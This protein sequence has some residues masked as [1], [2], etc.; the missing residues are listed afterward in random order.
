VP[1]GAIW[2]KIEPLPCSFQVISDDV[3]DSPGERGIRAP[4]L[5]IAG[6]AAQIIGVF[7]IILHDVGDSVH[8]ANRQVLVQNL[9]PELPACRKLQLAPEVL[10]RIIRSGRGPQ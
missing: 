10:E 9:Y 7:Q 6:A 5:V 4:W 2:T 3:R 8:G 1:S